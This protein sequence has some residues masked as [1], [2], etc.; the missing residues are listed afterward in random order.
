M[1]TVFTVQAHYEAEPREFSNFEDAARHWDRT[2]FNN[3]CDGGIGIV[4]WN[5]DGLMVRDG[6]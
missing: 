3:P 6:W 5:A 4:Q 2:T 1:R